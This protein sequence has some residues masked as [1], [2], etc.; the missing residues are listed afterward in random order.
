MLDESM[1]TGDTV[2]SSDGI[3][4]TYLKN[5]GACDTPAGHFENCSVY[6]VDGERYGLTH[7]ETWLCDGIGIVRQFVTRHADSYEWVL[8]SYKTGGKGGLL[9]FEAGNHWEYAL[10]TPETLRITERENIFEVTACDAGSV[11]LSSMNF[12]V[13]TGYYDTWEGKTAEARYCD[14][15]NITSDDA[16][17]C[18]VSGAMKCAEELAVTKRQKLHTAVANKVMQAVI[19]TDP[20]EN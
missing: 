1:K 19:A 8:S 12:M 15:K 7:C 14:C 13:L 9:P 4:L 2:T 3:T 18:D 10:A 6:V 16:I 11:T 17:L 20:H 5:D